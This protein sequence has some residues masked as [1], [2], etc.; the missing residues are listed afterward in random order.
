MDGS[1]SRTSGTTH[2]HGGSSFSA[3]K[4][5]SRRPQ[6]FH[7]AFSNYDELIEERLFEIAGDTDEIVIEAANHITDVELSVFHLDGQLA[8]RISAVVVQRFEFGLTAAGRQDFL[9]KVFE[10]AP[11]AS[12]LSNRPRV[13]TVAFS[14]ASQC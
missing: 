5:R 4:R 1:K 12:D 11:D 10:R 9:P 14:S 7:V 13:T 3:K 6:R 2:R 8:D